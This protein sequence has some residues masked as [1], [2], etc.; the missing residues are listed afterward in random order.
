MLVVDGVFDTGLA[1]TLDAFDVA[2]FLSERKHPFRVQLH[3]VRKTVNTSHG[4]R[5]PSEPVRPRAR[6]PDVV[7]VPALGDKAP[8]ALGTA[9]ERRDIV[10]AQEQ[11]RR[12]YAKGTRVAA[13]CTG[14]YMV[15]ASGLLDGRRATTTWWLG[16]DF[17]TR[18]PAVHLDDSRMVVTDER[19]VTAGAALGHV[20]LAL[21]IIRQ[22]SPTLAR[23]TSNF[24]LFDD[25]P[26]QSRY[27]MTD[28]I[29][30]ADPVIERFERW[31]REHLADFSM[32][33]A[34]RAVGASERTL[35]RR[36][37][38]VLGRSPIAYVRDLRVEQAVHWLETT[39]SSVEQVAE[40]VGY[41][42][43]ATLRRL[44]RTKTGRGVRELRSGG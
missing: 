33:A 31:A 8:A 11:L 41:R 21:W 20:D 29:A 16:A 28:H 19:L 26:T 18:F 10:D 1:S 40:A 25:R 30:Y 39:D 37:H 13:A 34:A 2:N 38:R 4:M 12:W 6:R 35:E 22:V 14:T 24:L 36:M 44:L 42:D 43:G 32:A 7:I 17:R 15:A 5:V 3:A 23:Q 9:L 27:A